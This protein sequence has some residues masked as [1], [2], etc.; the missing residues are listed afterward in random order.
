MAKKVKY[1]IK[2]NS[3]GYVY[4][5]CAALINTPNEKEAKRFDNKKQIEA[6]KAYW[7]RGKSDNLE[8]IKIN[9]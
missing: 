2:W 3:G 1:L 9:K 5:H 6:F 8:V 7:T 4:S